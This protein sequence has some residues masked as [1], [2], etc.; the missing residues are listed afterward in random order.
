MKTPKIITMK[1]EALKKERAHIV[2]VQWM[3]L[4]GERDCL[5]TLIRRLKHG[6]RSEH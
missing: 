6:E 5:E 3:L 1:V 4:K 2:K